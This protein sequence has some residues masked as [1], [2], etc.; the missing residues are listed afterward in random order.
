M[1]ACKAL[2]WA[3]SCLMGSTKLKVSKCGV[4]MKFWLDKFMFVSDIVPTNNLQADGLY[5]CHL[6][7]HISYIID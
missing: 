1:N 3:T 6:A 2:S 4:Y 5:N 7:F